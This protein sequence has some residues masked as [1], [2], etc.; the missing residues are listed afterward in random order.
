[1]RF[2]AVFNEFTDI[3]VFEAAVYSQAAVGFYSLLTVILL[4]VIKLANLSLNDIIHSGKVEGSFRI[5]WL[6]PHGA[7]LSYARLRD[8]HT[9]I[10]LPPPLLITSSNIYFVNELYYTKRRFFPKSF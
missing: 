1:M 6:K 2:L 4:V 3:L 8:S 7:L 9:H 5:D 10:Y